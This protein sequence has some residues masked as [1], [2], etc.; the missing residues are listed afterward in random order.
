[1]SIFDTSASAICPHGQHFLNESIGPTGLGK[2]RGDLRV[3][4][5]RQQGDKTIQRE[6]YDRSW[7]GRGISDP[8]KTMTPPPT[9]APTPTPVAPQRPI[10]RVGSLLEPSSPDIGL[11]DKEDLVSDIV[12]LARRGRRSRSTVAFHIVAATAS[13]GAG[14]SNPTQGSKTRMSSRIVWFVNRQVRTR[15]TCERKE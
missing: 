11:G 10:V 8:G 13:I 12:Q 5:G 1:M 2:N 14:S 15:L 7:P 3:T 9:M 6:S 4:H